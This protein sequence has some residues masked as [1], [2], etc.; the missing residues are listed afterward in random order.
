MHPSPLELQ[1]K[2]LRSSD[3]AEFVAVADLYQQAFPESERKPL[4]VL[5]TMLDDERYCFLHASQDRCFAGFAI[6]RILRNDTAALLEYMAI[7]PAQR[8]RG[9]GRQ[10]FVRTA[11]AIQSPPLTLLIEAESDHVESPDRELRSDRKRF[12]RSLGAREFQGLSWI[13]PPVASTA[14]PAMEMLA[15]GAAG[16]SI[17]KEHLRQWLASIYV[18]VYG[19]PAGDPRIE[20]MLSS[21]PDEVTLV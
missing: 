7:A 17:R 3:E 12:Y 6:V 9:S 13:M 10:L 5:R 4:A 11:N 20:T 18:E 8:G 19:Q 21:L 1:L 2:Q 14:P 16:D 15:L